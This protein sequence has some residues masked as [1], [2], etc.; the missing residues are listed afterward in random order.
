MVRSSEEQTLRGAAGS[1]G[2]V[3]YAVCILWGFRYTE[4]DPRLITKT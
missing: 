3:K 2:K 1:T 4:T